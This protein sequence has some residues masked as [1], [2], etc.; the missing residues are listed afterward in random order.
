MFNWKIKYED[1]FGEMG[2]IDNIMYILKL[3]SYKKNRK[4]DLL[5][6]F[7]L[8][9]FIRAI[10]WKQRNDKLCINQQLSPKSIQ[11]YNLTSINL[12][13][14]YRFYPFAKSSFFPILL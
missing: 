6:V 11:F 3:L 13:K 4:Y 10:L 2:F 1:H 12:E 14:V 7:F 8:V 9:F 5:L